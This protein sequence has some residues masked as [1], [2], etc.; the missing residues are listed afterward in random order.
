MEY[1]ELLSILKEKYLKILQFIVAFV[2]LFLVLFFLTPETYITE[3]TLYIYPINN[4]KQQQEVSSD[5]NFARNIIGVSES[6]EFKRNISKLDVSFI[7]FVGVSVGYKLKE[8]T[9]NLVSITVKYS[10][11]VDNLVT[12]SNNLKKG[13]ANFTI[14]NLE[15]DPVTYK[16]SNNIYLN[17]FIGFVLGLFFGITYFYLKK[18][19]N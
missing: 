16:V 11:Y 15:S 6:P 14:E 17:I 12:F 10:E 19:K 7:P 5:M 8:V 2:L 13:N 3:G 9:P 18:G 1:V 4:F